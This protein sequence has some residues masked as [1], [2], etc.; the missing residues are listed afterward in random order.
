MRGWSR[1]IHELSKVIPNRLG[2]FNLDKE[3]DFSRV[4]LA[5]ADPAREEII[6][7]IQEKLSG[8]AL[9]KDPL[10]PSNEEVLLAAM[11]LVYGG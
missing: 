11:N 4:S 2:K 1:D 10:D 5:K 9:A 8:E 6:R 3:I 7:N